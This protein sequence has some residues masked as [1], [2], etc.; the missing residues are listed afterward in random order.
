[1]TDTPPFQLSISTASPGLDATAVKNRQAVVDAYKAI[2]A[3]DPNALNALLDPNIVFIEADSLPYGGT[4]HGIEGAQAGV[5]GMFG[6]WSHLKV[7]IE[8]I[9]AS[10]DMTL[11]YLMMT[12]TSRATG[13]VY[14]GHTAEMF[15]FKNGKIIEWRPIYWDTHAARIACGLD[16]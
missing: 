8:D 7:E 15:R 6:A 9:L 1:M 12:S 13:K 16:R 5:A 11:A 4:F 10:G 2:E 3:G 14:K